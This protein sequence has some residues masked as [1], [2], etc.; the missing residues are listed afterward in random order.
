MSV[1]V[2]I[3]RVSAGLVVAVGLIML[4]SVYYPKFKQ[5]RDFNQKQIQLEEEIR[6]DEEVLRHL[7][8]KQQKLLNDPRFVEKIAREELGMAKPGE[9]VFRFVDDPTPLEPRTGAT[10]RA[11]QRN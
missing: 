11:G 2:L 7:R 4:A 1:W 8:L 3:Y 10:S 6:R 9:T 5:I